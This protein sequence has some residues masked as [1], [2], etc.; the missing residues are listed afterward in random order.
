MQRG[1]TAVRAAWLAGVWLLACGPAGHEHSGHAG[2]SGGAEPPSVEG[3]VM[4]NGLPVL[5]RLPGFDLVDEQGEAFSREHLEGAV[6]VSD[7]IFTTCP[8]ACPMLTR[9]MAKLQQQIVGNP[10]L[11]E[12]RLV[13]FSVD[14][15]TD[16]PE[17]LREY[18]E[19]Y[20][21]DLERWSF[22]TGT[23]PAL[24][25]LIQGGF[26]LA[27]MEN[28]D[29]AGAPFLHSQKFVLADRQGR[30]RGYYD[31][32]EAADRRRLV[33]DLRRLVTAPRSS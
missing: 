33:Q 14:P 26:K 18:A 8:D 12:V 15:E 7:F 10:A 11:R 23:R 4:E 5:V 25:E 6:S 28:A 16:T 13:S 9:E 22:V 29:A 31:A 27:V 19:R 17:A 20:G 21:A 1:T 30:I 3:A 2:A 32:L 24:M